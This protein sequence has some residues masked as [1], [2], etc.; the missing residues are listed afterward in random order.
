ME[1]PKYN[2]P[3]SLIPGGCP[4]FLDF[5][6][7]PDGL[8][9]KILR[10]SRAFREKR[11][12]EAQGDGRDA[13]E[14]ICLDEDENG[15]RFDLVTGAAVPEA[16]D[17]EIEARKSLECFFDQWIPLPVLRMREVRRPDGEP[18][19]TPGPSNWARCRVA[20]P[21][22][23]S[24]RLRVVVAFL[25]VAVLTSSMGRVLEGAAA[26]EPGDAWRHALLLPLAVSAAGL[27]GAELTADTT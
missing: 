5:D 16:P 3:V 2:Y 26:L 10:F 24:K 17:Y 6:I 23:G 22:E 18:M 4:Q 19:F 15:R 9:P 1:A 11:R 21:T 27:V 7:D 13:F 20:A 12:P 25:A 8:D 14:L